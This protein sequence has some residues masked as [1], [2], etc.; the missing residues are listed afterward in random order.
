[1]YSGEDALAMKL[2]DLREKVQDAFKAFDH[3]NNN[4]VDVREIGTIIRSLGCVPTEADL[5]DIFSQLEEE[6]LPGLIRLEKFVELMV[7]V[8]QEKKYPPST[9]QM[10]NYA[11]QILDKKKLGYF[12]PEQL[13]KILTQEGEPFTQEEMDEMLSA[14]TN[15]ETN[16]IVYKDLVALMFQDDN[17]N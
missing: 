9:E 2:N 4:T 17:L 5:Q 10:L 15:P 12:T 11:F 14:S 6:D 13:Q 8:L 3:E 7:Q 16:T 1:M